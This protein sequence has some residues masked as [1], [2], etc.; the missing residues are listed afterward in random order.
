MSVIH[1]IY[2]ILTDNEDE[3]NLAP[4]HGAMRCQWS[5]PINKTWITITTNGETKTANLK[6]IIELGTSTLSKHL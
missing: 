3:D 6:Y 2:L 1:T 4:P 5:M